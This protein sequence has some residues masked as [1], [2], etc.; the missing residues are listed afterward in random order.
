MRVAIGIHRLRPRGGQEDHCIRIAEALVARGHEVTLISGDD[1]GDL[2]IPTTKLYRHGWQTNHTWANRFAAAFRARTRHGFDRTVAFQPT[3]GV[4]I[5]FIGDDLRS[6]TNTG[7]LVRLTPRYRVF[8]RLES[9]CFGSGSNVK[10]VGYSTRQMQ[11]F[12]ERY[13]ESR[14]R[15]AVLPPTL[16]FERYRPELRARAARDAQRR[17]LGIPDTGNVWLWLGLHPKVKGLDRVLLALGES[18][19][20][21]L[22]IGGLDADHP[23]ARHIRR[24]IHDQGLVGRVT[25]LGYLT[26]ERYSAALAA[27]DV[28]AHPARKEAAGMTIL[29]AVVNGLPVVATDI[30]GFAE[31][32]EKSGTGIVLP[33]PFNQAAFEEAL[34]SAYGR[35]REEFSRRG[36]EYGT[37]P[38]LFSGIDV[39]CDL[40]E[41]TEWSTFSLNGLN[42]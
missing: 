32:I 8:S 21:H 30:C 23:K 40:I 29:E 9:E 18:K 13:P 11:A 14:R 3:S 5:L 39:A 17:M 35:R 15:I 6:R 20:A 26:G 12:A 4:D 25:F 24:L 28:L 33:S 16:Q 31:H 36:I 19:S 37:D 38:R 42:D 7:L 41:D 34:S 1:A 10:V 22:L 2:P 27:A